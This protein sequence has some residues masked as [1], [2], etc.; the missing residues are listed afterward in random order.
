MI[1]AII[2]LM[3]VKR[4]INGYW[5]GTGRMTGCSGSECFVLMILGDGKLVRGRL[6]VF[7][8]IGK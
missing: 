6:L 1:G 7:R 5:L 4:V 3:S 2:I 8:D